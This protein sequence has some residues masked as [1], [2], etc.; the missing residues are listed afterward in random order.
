MHIRL[1]KIL[2]S[3]ESIKHLE[4]DEPLAKSRANS[5]AYAPEKEP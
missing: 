1:R 2:A 3:T 5:G 4:A